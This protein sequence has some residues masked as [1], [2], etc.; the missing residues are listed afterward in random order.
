MLDIVELEIPRAVPLVLE[1]DENLEVVNS[2]CLRN[3]FRD[4]IDKSEKYF[5]CLVT[6]EELKN[7]SDNDE[8]YI[9]EAEISE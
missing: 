7:R 3:R 2:Y 4:L 9:E 1:L 6:E 8:I 5:I